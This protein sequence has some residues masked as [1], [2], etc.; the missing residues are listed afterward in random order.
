MLCCQHGSF[1]ASGV[2]AMIMPPEKP[3]RMHLGWGFHTVHCGGGAGDGTGTEAYSLEYIVTIPYG[4][5]NKAAKY[6]HSPE[7]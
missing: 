2:R 1:I 5:Q 6:S 4:P 3:A 7:E